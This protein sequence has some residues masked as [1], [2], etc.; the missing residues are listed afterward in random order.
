MER[1]G[2]P[3]SGRS[4]NDD[5]SARHAANEFVFPRDVRLE[6]QFLQA[7]DSLFLGQ[8]S[9]DELFS[10]HRGHDGKPQIGLQV[11]IHVVYV[12]PVVENDVG[13]V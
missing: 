2:F 8:D 9:R 13:F 10:V 6:S 12:L 5:D 11:L 7:R 4:G 3:A 1:R